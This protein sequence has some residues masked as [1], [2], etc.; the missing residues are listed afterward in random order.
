MT[1]ETFA[2]Y[3]RKWRHTEFA[4][5]LTLDR[6]TYEG[7]IAHDATVQV[8]GQG[9]ITQAWIKQTADAV[10]W[11]QIID[12]FK[13]KITPVK[14]E[15]P[16]TASEYMLEI[17]LFDMH[18]GVAKLKDYEALNAEIIS[19]IK[20]KDYE[21]INI[22]VGQ[23]LIHTND[24]RGHTAKGTEIERIDVPKAWAD[25]WAF[26]CRVIEAALS[27]AKQVNLRYSKG[28]HDECISW[29]FTKALEAKFP[30][31]NV[32]DEIKARKLIFWRGCFIGYG[33]CEYTSKADELFKQ[34][35]CD[36]SNQFASAKVRE[37]H[38][39]HLHRESADS[40][41]FVR[42]LASAVPVD[43]WHDN[44]GYITAHKRFQ[45]FEWIPNKLK[46]IYYI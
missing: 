17:P 21:E 7:F 29:C 38:T 32:D 14:I 26:W 20:S 28:N 33:H 19:L 27:H 6:G 2:R 46:A 11:Q 3:L 45:L 36:F 40:G 8:N 34:F 10:D 5:P 23:D 25:A 30:D 44:N 41:I 13:D 1:F 22:L 24:F 37:I 16:A 9:E 15:A 35:V 4:D 39:G 12:G 18:F 31:L 42:R 43:E